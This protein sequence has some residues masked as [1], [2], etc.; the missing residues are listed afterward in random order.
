[1]LDASLLPT[2]KTNAL[3]NLLTLT[4]TLIII[5]FIGNVYVFLRRVL[6]DNDSITRQVGLT[7]FQVSS[8]LTC[9]NTSHW[10]LLLIHSQK[11]NVFHLRRKNKRFG[12]WNIC[13][14]FKSFL[15]LRV[16]SK[17]QFFILGLY[18]WSRISYSSWDTLFVV[19][20]HNKIY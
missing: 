19:Y 1:M 15:W 6:V 2:I 11:M 16:M 20:K 4:Y 14:Y 5:F 17:L 9:A 10:D 7:N 3:F 12:E 8:Q 18:L 13:N